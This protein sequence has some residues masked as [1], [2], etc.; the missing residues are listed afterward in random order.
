MGSTHNKNFLFTTSIFGFNVIL[1]FN[2][3]ELVL[4]QSIKL[5]TMVS[6]CKKISPSDFPIGMCPY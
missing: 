3:F 5:T 4:R 6:I 2:M 1:K